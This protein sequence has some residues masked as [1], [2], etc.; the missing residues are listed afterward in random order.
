CITA[1]A[2][3]PNLIGSPTNSRDEAQIVDGRIEFVNEWFPGHLPP[4]TNMPGLMVAKL[5]GDH[6]V[7]GDLC[8]HARCEI[9]SSIFG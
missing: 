8:H 7:R 9:T 5:V 6:K 4:E 1:S 3:Y 2:S